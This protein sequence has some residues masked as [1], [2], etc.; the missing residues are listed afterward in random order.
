MDNIYFEELKAKAYNLSVIGP[1]DLQIY[2]DEIGEE[3]NGH[4]GHV[5]YAAMVTSSWEKPG[6]FDNL[7]EKMDLMVSFVEHLAQ[8]IES[9]RLRGSCKRMLFYAANILDDLF[10]EMKRTRM[11]RDI[12]NMWQD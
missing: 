7:L 9:G 1:G 6:Y 3:I 10:M 2:G 8:L 4:P 5:I 12:G 11:A